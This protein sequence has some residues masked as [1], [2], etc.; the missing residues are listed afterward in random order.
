G[1]VGI[2]WATGT[3]LNIQ[4]F[5]GVLMMVGISVSNSVLMVEF[6][7]RQRKAGL[8]TWS[9]IVSAARIRLQPILMT[10]LATIVG[11]TP[12]ALHLHPGD[13]MNIP[14]ARAV[15]GGLTSS[16]LLTLFVVPVLYVLLKPGGAADG[17]GATS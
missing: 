1:V 3:S 9:A 14:L 17:A 11:L 16:T 12:M 4:S 7:N 2:L 6:A 10:T 15:I 8:D 5:M 13:E